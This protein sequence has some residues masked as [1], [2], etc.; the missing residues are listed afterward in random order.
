TAPRIAHEVP[1]W[2]AAF[3]VALTARGAGDPDLALVAAGE[4]GLAVVDVAHAAAPTT[5]AAVA[6]GFSARR[7]AAAGDVAYV[8]GSGR[9]AAFD[10][11]DPRAPVLLGVAATAGT[12]QD[13]AV[14]G[15]NVL[16]ADGGAGLTV[17]DASDPA[18]LTATGSVTATGSYFVDVVVD[19]PHVFAADTGFGL[20]V[21]D[22]A[23]P[24]APR[25]AASVPYTTQWESR[26]LAL[27][28]DRLF[29]VA[30]QVPI[31]RMFEG[32]WPEDVLAVEVTDPRAPRAEGW[33]EVGGWP[34][35]MATDAGRLYL[36]SGRDTGRDFG[37]FPSTVMVWRDVAAG[38]VG[39]RQWSTKLPEVPQG[40]AAA[41]DHAYVADREAGLMVVDVSDEALDRPT[42]PPSPTPTR[43]PSATPRP[44]EV[45]ATPL[46]TSTVLPSPTAER[47]APPR[48]Y[49]PAVGNTGG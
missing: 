37:P 45:T 4:S 3:D 29:A 20:R 13:F 1:S 49:L 32:E 11:T 9:V 14:Q 19:G 23:D 16:V 27:G 33:L 48:V 40:V 38:P 22:T 7:V 10:V 5:L 39:A 8:A 36:V 34:K 21:V 35:G 26:G 31:E 15:D 47:P 17:M 44:G 41:G 30:S 2:Q 25:I 24:A 28:G 46:P 42:P 43:V 18:R 6:A 12:A